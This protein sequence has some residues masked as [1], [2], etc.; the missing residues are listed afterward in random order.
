MKVAATGVAAA[1][2]WLLP[3]IAYA[4]AGPVTAPA[5]LSS[6]ALPGLLAGLVLAA[7]FAYALWTY[8]EP[9]IRQRDRTFGAVLI[10][11]IALWGVKT[12]AL[13]IFGGLAIDLG[14]YQAWALRMAS[15]GPAE[16]YTPGYFLDYPPGYLYI[17]WFAGWLANLFG[18][19]GDTLRIFIET[20][21]LAADFL[22]AAVAYIFFRRRDQPRA[23]LVAALLMALNP[24][25][26]FDTVGWGQSDSVV[27]L[28]MFLSVLML[29]ESEYELGWSFVAFSLLIKPQAVCLLPVLGL[30][31]LLRGEWRQ[32]WRAALAALA[33]L[34]IGVAPFQIG[35][36]LSWLPQLY[37]ST[38]G[39]YHE[40]SLNAFNL[41]ALIGGLR[42][43]DGGTLLGVSYFVIGMA[44]LAPL[45][46]F[47]AFIMWRNPSRHNLIYLSFLAIF[48]FFLLAPRMH[49]R[50]IYPALVFAVPL[51]VAE[52]AML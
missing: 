17:L 23:A 49:E 14:T 51:A 15:V 47:I 40:T 20:P 16:M 43:N 37:L 36:P 33:V 39:Y 19:S 8:A 7:L 46:A 48:G 42:Q 4:A 24:A 52:P 6:G 31:T 41:M 25:L 35:H 11:L 30:W 34:I 45:Y 5:A 3:S 18:A 10:G 27:A 1:M 9:L 22:L 28:T 2:I 50:Y 29:L 44:M 21:P 26:L 12:L 38:M 32:W 13:G